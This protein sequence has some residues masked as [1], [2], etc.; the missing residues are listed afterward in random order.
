MTHAGFWKRA[1]AYFIDIIPI[2]L[3]VIAIFSKYFGYSEVLQSRYKNPND[4]KARVEFLIQRNMIKN[5][6]FAIWL[7]TCVL[8]E[9]TPLQGTVGKKMLGIKVVTKDGARPSFPQVLF[10]T[11]MKIPSYIVIGI[12]FIWIAF[13][14]EKQGWH[15]KLAKTFV[16]DKSS[17]ITNERI[18][19]K[20]PNT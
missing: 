13:S 7:I 18:E 20:L 6:S 19:L 12:G 17:L 10:R 4:P 16:V 1:F 15:D 11:L 5:L 14:R 8:L 2:A 3:I 9:S